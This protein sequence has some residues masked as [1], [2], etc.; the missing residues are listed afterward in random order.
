M[1]LDRLTLLYT[2]LAFLVFGSLGFVNWYMF[3]HA[4]ASDAALSALLTA[5]GAA[6]GAFLGAA[7]LRGWLRQ[8]LR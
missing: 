5:L 2:V 3:R 7:V 1:T 4:A 8:W 6:I